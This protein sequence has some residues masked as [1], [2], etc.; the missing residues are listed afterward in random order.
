MADERGTLAYLVRLWS[1]KDE[2]T[3]LAKMM[4]G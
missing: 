3:A 4:I 2:L 1:V